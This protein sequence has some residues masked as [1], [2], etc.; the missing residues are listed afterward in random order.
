MS[1]NFLIT[2]MSATGKSSAIAELRHRGFR[3]IDADDGF[4]E[5]GPEGDWVWIESRIS[6]LLSESCDEPL[7][8]SGCASNQGRF[9]PEFDRVILLVAPV[10]VLLA[11]LEQRQ[12]NTFGKSATERARILADLEEFEPVLR[13]SSHVIID[14]SFPLSEV[15]DQ[16]L[17]AAGLSE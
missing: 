14:T 6:Q 17:S 16:I 2:G 1:A 8:L 4:S 10:E 3:G 7:F 5:A 13:R 15:V 11:R 9:Y 12:S